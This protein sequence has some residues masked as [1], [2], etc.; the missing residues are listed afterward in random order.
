MSQNIIQ[1]IT[2]KRMRREGHVALMNENRN[3]YSVCVGK[4]EGKRPLRRPSCGW[5]KTLKWSYIGQKAVV[6]INVLQDREK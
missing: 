1:A 6:W 2:S 5:E 3:A 4:S